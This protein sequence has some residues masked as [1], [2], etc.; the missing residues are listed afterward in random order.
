MLSGLFQ[1]ITT[2]K[3]NAILKWLF[4]PFSCQTVRI[5][6]AHKYAYSR[7]SLSR[8][9][10]YLVLIITRKERMLQNRNNFRGENWATIAHFSP[11]QKLFS[12]MNNCS[13][14][15]R[16]MKKKL[17]CYPCPKMGLSFHK[18]LVSYL[19]SPQDLSASQL[20][21]L[22]EKLTHKLDLM[23]SLCSALLYVCVPC[24]RY[25]H[26][27]PSKYAA[28]YWLYPI[29]R[30]LKPARAWCDWSC[31]ELSESIHNLWLS[32]S[33]YPTEYEFSS[34]NEK[35]FIKC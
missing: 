29:T 26:D 27:R 22:Y 31:L 32:V 13:G 20:L 14:K 18:T 10:M 17:S 24:S 9:L 11:C 28:A 33:C 2:N 15:V 12:L 19:P 25:A 21:A 16:V 5:F 1:H 3:S 35:K 34:M 8:T 7:Q 6:L 4:F 30:A 23:S